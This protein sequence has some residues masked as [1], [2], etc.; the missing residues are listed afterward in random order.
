MDKLFLRH[1]NSHSLLIIFLGW[2]F[3]PES[4]AGIN[5]PGFNILLLSRYRGLSGSDIDR[6]IAETIRTEW[7]DYER[8][9]GE[10][11]VI[12]W[13]F[14][15][16]AASAFL[17]STKIPVT[18]CMAVNGTEHHIDDS[19]GIPYS[20]FNG[21][22]NGLSENSFA[23]FRLRSA[24]SRDLLA[25]LDAKAST[26]TI[27]IEDLRDELRWFASMSTSTSDI[28][29]SIWD[30]IIVGMDDRIFPPENQITSWE[31]HDIFTIKGMPHVPDFQWLIE[32]FIIDK[33]KVCDKF[34]MAGL[35]YSRNAVIQHASARKLY[36]R[37][38][39]VFD[40]CRLKSSAAYNASQMSV[41][42]LGYGDGT[43]TDLYIKD[44][45]TSCRLVTL[46]DI[47]PSPDTDTLKYSSITDK[48]HIVEIIHDDAESIGFARECLSDK[49]RD[50]IF[51]SSMFQWLNSP[52]TMLE[53]CAN[54]LRDDGVIALSYY[55]PGTFKEIQETVG[56]GLKYPSAEWMERIAK[57]CDLDIAILEKD[58]ET[59]SF[60]SPA[61]ALRH[62]RLTGVNALPG[63][64]SPSRTRY[65]LENWPLD[66]EGK[67]TLTF[68]PVYMILTKR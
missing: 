32:T 44:F 28:C 26:V 6:E 34:S 21:T 47:S 25:K 24:G 46:T 53:R 12:G 67:A 20:I 64:P 23:K 5:K 3:P 38:I 8:D 61:E 17:A 29:R 68:C 1:D 18:L 45:I 58:T 15:V 7:K 42:E 37:F 59:L 60:D 54:A 63:I 56:T 10:V 13:S 57:E 51:S 11:I 33:R 40:T 16:K 52:K 43:F 39:S 27:D 30:K 9:C 50:I 4:F 41:I 62:L 66:S 35:T 36:D 2:G 22:L 31:G 49:S 19:R 14:G 55:G 65:L 48:N